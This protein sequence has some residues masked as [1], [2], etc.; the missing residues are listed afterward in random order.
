[1]GRR[2]VRE[3]LEKFDLKIMKLDAGDEETIR[4][5]NRP[6]SPF[7]LEVIVKG[8]QA[9]R[10]VTLQSLFVQGRVSNVEPSIL[11]AWITRIVE[12]QPTLVQVYSLDRLPADRGLRKVERPV[13][14][15]IARLVEERTG[16]R[17]EVY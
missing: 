8:L 11:D 13:L 4:Q 3:A 16:I 17:A 5:L 6:A 14:E 1:V 10:E 15:R 2:E 9:L 12:I 7:D